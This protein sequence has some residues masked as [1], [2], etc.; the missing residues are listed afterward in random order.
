M[1]QHYARQRA[2]CHGCG[3][4]RFEPFDDSGLCGRCAAA[5]R[6]EC[7][8]CKAKVSLGCNTCATCADERGP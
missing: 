6:G 8:H 1:T 7:Q 3:G 4:M 5:E 2:Y